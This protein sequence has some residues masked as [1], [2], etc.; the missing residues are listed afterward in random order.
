[1]QHLVT[2]AQ[3]QEL[4]RRTIAEYGIP[5]LTLMENA[6][7]GVVESMEKHLGTIAGTRPLVVCGK[8]NNGGDGFVVARLLL[9]K[10]AKPDC[11]LLGRAADITGDALFNYRLLAESGLNVHE[12]SSGADIEPLFQNR[13]LIVDAVFGTGLTRAPSG[14]AADAIPLINNSRAYV[15]AV[16]L[17]SG[18]RSDTGVPYDPCVRADLTVTMAWPKLGLWLYPGRTLAGKV[19]V[20]DIGMPGTKNQGPVPKDEAP[21]FLLDA[22]HVRSILP[23]RRPDGNKGTF[24]RALLIVGSRSYSGAAILAGR[25][26]VRSGCGIV[27]LAV[28][29]GIIDV[30][31]SSVVEAVK[32]SQPQ[33]ADATLSPAALESLLDMS[34]EAQAIAIG[35]G[36]GTDRRTQK[37]ELDFLAEVEKPTVV[38]ADGLNNLVGRLDLLP[39]IKPPMVLTPHPGEFARLTGIKPAD[40][41]ADRVGLSRKFAVEHKVVLVL[42][43]ASTV[44]AAPDGRVFVNPTGNSGLATGGTGDV[45][46]GLIVGLMAQGMSP[47]EA[48]CAG[49][50]LH[51]LAA[52]IAAQSL[53]EYCLTAGDLPDFL[54]KAYAAVLRD[55]SEGSRAGLN[56]P[57]L[58]EQ[59]F[60][61]IPHPG[62]PGPLYP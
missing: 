29:E 22:D 38:D 53:T 32:S 46:T 2:A 62:T 10:N 28:P 41:N 48:S 6:G 8:G 39:R 52:D 31:A 61:S 27:Q 40:A 42:K 60:R 50:F 44:V 18:L 30:V 49:V 23:R 21:A 37:L 20:V 7:R 16:D 34:T 51:G 26:A 36:I 57:C 35:P 47:L 33:T 12:A 4:D 11:V 15:V 3:M 19:E 58:T 56:G 1:M 43:G 54:P 25:T 17:P 13:K 55:G 14:L 24:G 59:E 9:A 5:G 45:L